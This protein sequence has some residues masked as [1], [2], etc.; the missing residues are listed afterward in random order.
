M[1]RDVAAP[2]WILEAARVRGP[3][4]RDCYRVIVVESSGELSSKD[5]EDRALA[6]QYANDAA[7]ESD[8]PSP[9]A[10]VFGDRLQLVARGR[11]Y[12]DR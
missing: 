7:S 4:S 10:Y 1:S 9:V 11:H 12:A 2:E 8:H 5:F 3:I 6:E